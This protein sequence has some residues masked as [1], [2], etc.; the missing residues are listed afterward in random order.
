MWILHCDWL[1]PEAA[2]HASTYLAD[3]AHG[4]THVEAACVA[5]ADLSA[6]WVSWAWALAGGAE[7]LAVAYI[8]VSYTHLRA[9][10]T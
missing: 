1:A 2:R 8:P 3:Y 10:E 7:R 6:A 4:S 5:V 9:H